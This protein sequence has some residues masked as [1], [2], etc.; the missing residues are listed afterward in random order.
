[1]GHRPVRAGGGTPLASPPMPERSGGICGDGACRALTLGDRRGHARREG[2][3]RACAPGNRRASAGSCD[4]GRSGR[5]GR[6][7]E[8]ARGRGRH[9]L[10]SPDRARRARL[11]TPAH[12]P[13]HVIRGGP[14]AQAGP[15][16]V[17]EGGGGT[18]SPRPTAL[19]APGFPR[20]PRRRRDPRKSRRRCGRGGMAG[21]RPRSA[22]GRGMGRPHRENRW[23]PFHAFHAAGGTPGSPEGGV[24]GVGWRAPARGRQGVAAWEG[25]TGR[26]DGAD[27]SMMGFCKCK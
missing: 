4:P 17:R 3:P 8:G 9:A 14:A 24:G 15:G 16:R 23:G 27:R 2:G 12:L 22:R 6:A 25:P 19:G 18:P 11:S 5:P 7:G 13:G 26:T 21:A 10:P 20:L 1:M